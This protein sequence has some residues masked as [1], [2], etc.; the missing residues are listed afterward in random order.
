MSYKDRNID[1]KRMRRTSTKYEYSQD[2]LTEEISREKAK[3]RQLRNSSWWR[4]KISSGKCY[5]CGRTFNPADLTMDHKIPL[6]RGGKSEK[7]NLVPACKECNNKKKYM[8]PTEWDDYM[9]SLK[10]QNT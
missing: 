3:A 10:T 5:Y 1:R 4:N 2:F 6:S 8:L 7:I 9:E